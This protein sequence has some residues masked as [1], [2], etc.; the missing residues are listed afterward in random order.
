M[1]N[2][3]WTNN[4]IYETYSKQFGSKYAAVNYLA[5]DARN[6][7]DILNNRISHSDSLN[8][9]I[10]GKQPNHLFDEESYEEKSYARS[11]DRLNYVLDQDVKDS[12]ELTISE[13]RKMKHLI[14][15]YSKESLSEPVMSRIRVLSNLIWNKVRR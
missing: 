9:V 7:C 5:S 8:W 10:T 11:L 14:Y 3:Y 4:S 1:I 15:I 12:V 13:S 6:R 2:D